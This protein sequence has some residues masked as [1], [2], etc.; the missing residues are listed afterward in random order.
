MMVPD[1]KR[2]PKCGETKALAE[3]RVCR[4]NKD[5]RQ[6]WCTICHK[7]YVQARAEGFAARE[8][9]ERDCR[10]CLRCGVVKSAD[11][12][13]KDRTRPDGLFPYCHSCA[14]GASATYRVT[15]PERMKSRAAAYYIRHDQLIK[16]RSR[17]WYYENYEIAR[18]RQN[19]YYQSNRERIR[20]ARLL[21]PEFYREKNRRHRAINLSRLRAEGR[22]RYTQNPTYYVRR[23]VEWARAHPEWKRLNDQR[24]RARVAATQCTLTVAEWQDILQAQAYRCGMCDRPFGDMLRPCMDHIIPVVAGGGLTKENV[25]ALCRSCNSRKN[26]QM[27]DYRGGV[28]PRQLRLMEN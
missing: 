28:E 6:S 10:P 12:F 9:V 25:G 26:T 11:D 16:D 15:Y 1:T 5:G 2:C 14:N 8:T 13:G 3:F 19:T 7:A 20:T 18:Q 22:A 21:R 27:I 23:A 4:R 24:R 17:A